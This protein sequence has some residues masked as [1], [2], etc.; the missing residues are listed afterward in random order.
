MAELILLR[1]AFRGTDSFDQLKRILDMLG[2]PNTAILQAICTQGLCQ[3]ENEVIKFPIEHFF[4]N[5]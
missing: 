2:T 3:I 5:V 1:P 4:R